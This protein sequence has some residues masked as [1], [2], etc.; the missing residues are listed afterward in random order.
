MTV[1]VASAV[2]ALVHDEPGA[3]LVAVQLGSGTLATAHL[4]EVIGKLVDV[5]VDVRRL[6]E[7]LA[8]AAVA[9]EPHRAGRRDGRCGALDPRRPMAV[10]GRPLLLGSDPSQHPAGCADGRPGAGRSRPSTTCPAHP[11][12][13][14]VGDE[15]FRRLD[16][17]ELRA[18]SRVLPTRLI[19]RGSGRSRCA[20]PSELR[21]PMTL[22]TLPP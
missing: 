20:P 7:L 15:P 12:A 19:A 8:A 13:E 6:P 9:I 18:R 5:G 2:L 1:L 11:V 10:A 14:S 16:G 22:R 17:D 4:A 3:D 21:A